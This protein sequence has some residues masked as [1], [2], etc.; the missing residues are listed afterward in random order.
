MK[1]LKLLFVASLLIAVTAGNS[2][3]QKNQITNS[4]TIT[5]ETDYINCIGVGPF[6]IEGTWHTTSV[7]GSTGKFKAKMHCTIT[8]QQTGEVYY[9]DRI[10]NQGWKWVPDQG[11]GQFVVFNLSLSDSDGNVLA[12]G[13][14]HG[15]LQINANG[16]PVVDFYG[17]VLFP[18]QIPLN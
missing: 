14:T 11:S 13:Q 17:W 9:Y 18:W 12:S 1:T 3:P 6:L 8:N 7:P 16:E 5:V 15:K 10:M 4:G 2:W